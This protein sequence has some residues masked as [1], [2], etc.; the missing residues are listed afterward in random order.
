MVCA[1]LCARYLERFRAADGVAGFGL[2]WDADT[3]SLWD[4]Y[5]QSW[6]KIEA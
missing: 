4:D 6:T 5:K 2:C 1:A 3:S